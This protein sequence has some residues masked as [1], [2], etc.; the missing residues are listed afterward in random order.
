MYVTPQEEYYRKQEVGKH[1]VILKKKSKWVNFY[2]L[3]NFVLKE[4]KPCG[5]K[6]KKLDKEELQK[7]ISH[8]KSKKQSKILFFIAYNFN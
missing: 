5:I 6:I 2:E 4:T 7:H 8:L 1:K 3:L